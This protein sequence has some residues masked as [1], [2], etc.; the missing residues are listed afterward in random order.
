MAKKLSLLALAGFSLA[1]LLPTGAAR[2]DAIDG[3]WC[4]TEVG[5]MSIRGPDIVT[6]GGT[7]MQGTYGRH[8]FSY[9]VP[10]GEPGAGATLFMLLVD[11]ETVHLTKGEGT[12]NAAP[13][14]WHRCAAD[15][16]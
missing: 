1:V 13:Q 8:S 2:A 3:N 14:I 12:A 7:Q 9:D 10:A 11:D 16:S 6:P 15:V 5:R 4:H